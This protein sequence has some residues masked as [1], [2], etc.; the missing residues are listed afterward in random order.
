VSDKYTDG[1]KR[2][3]L[4]ELRFLHTEDTLCKKWN[5]TKYRLGKWKKAANYAYLTPTFREM[6][7]VALHNGANT[8]PRLISYLDYL[9]H[10]IYTEAE[11]LK[12]LHDLRA[13]GIAREDSGLWLYD[14]AYSQNDTS[15]IF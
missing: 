5:L 7:I 8:I 6:V 11:I 14:Q 10:A 13:E 1:D 3:I 9:D 2:R 12:A 4:L 15:F